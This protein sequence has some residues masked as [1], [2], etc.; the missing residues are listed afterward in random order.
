MAPVDTPPTLS[1]PV[2]Y[3]IC[4]QSNVN[5][6]PLSREQL[7]I[8]YEIERTI[9]EIRKQN[10][11]RVALQ[12]P[13]HMLPDA[14]GIIG[15]LYKGL[16]TKSRAFENDVHRTSSLAELNL[17]KKNTL[18]EV[19]LYILADTSYG[20]C[21]VDEIAAEHVNADVIV[22][23]GRACLSPTARIPVIHV[24]TIQ[25]LPHRD[26][27]LRDFETFYRDKEQ[28]IILLADL[29]YQSHLIELHTV[30]RDSFGYENIY[31]TRVLHNPSSPL[32]NRSVPDEVEHDSS[33]LR[34]WHLFH[35]SD[36]PDSLLLSLA[37]RVASIRI[38]PTSSP[39]RDNR[40]EPFLAFTNRA[41]S[42][43]Y[44]LLT[45][46]TTVSIFGILIN[47]L[48][49]KNYLHI[50]EHVKAQVKLSGK[51]SYTFVVG[52]VNAAKVANFSEVGA[53]V[54][55]GCWEN[56]LIDSK[57]F[58]KPVLTP[59]E[60]DLALKPDNERLW[61][62]DWNSDFQ[63]LLNG[64]RA[65]SRLGRSSEARDNDMQ[66]CA[67]DADAADDFE[68]AP[69][70]F[71]LRNGR[72]ISSSKPLKVHSPTLQHDSQDVDQ[73]LMKRSKGDLAVV[74]G[75]ISAGAEHLQSQ[76]TWKGLGS[77]IELAYEEA[78]ALVEE[79]RSGIAASYVHEEN[80]VK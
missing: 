10:Y 26:I 69:P 32:P 71:D 2:E 28:K 30:L 17:G 23:Y 15:A 59:F 25:N 66:S 33:V 16:S 70:E 12:F 22:H 27:L 65:T 9:T 40:R 49:V 54:V 72:Y 63:K 47:T 58:W 68:S 46:V 21:C 80:Q 50:V 18:P 4:Q 48:S 7:Y 5:L 31:V 79:G 76:R 77:D 61:T 60:L 3:L 62:G 8:K 13:D 55:I 67:D 73:T 53:W 44:A 37:S 19:R 34:N 11:R 35:V 20:A 6:A 39:I 45:S 52:K 29:T 24:F 51:H 75:H 74:A 56:S 38:F 57:D 78:G 42:R 36:P 1:T 14:T 41:L 64:S 43:R